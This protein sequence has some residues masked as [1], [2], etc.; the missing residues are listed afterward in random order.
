MTRR[1]I[2]LGLVALGGLL[3]A[4]DARAGLLPISVSVAPEAGNFR[5]TYAI[6]LPTDSQLQAGD[7]FTIYDFGGL[8][9]DSVVAPDGWSVVVA[10]TGTTP[11]RLTPDDHAGLPNMTFTY[12]GPT[13][14]TG[15]TGLGN[16]WA[17]ST[18]QAATDSFLTA[19]THR[20]SDGAPDSN[21]T[22]VVV[23][24]PVAPPAVPEPATLA[25]AA[26]GLPLAALVR[27]RGTRAARIAVDTTAAG[28]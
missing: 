20:T 17:T 24:V 23:P 11:P 13:I 10:N 4:A 27:R 25:L 22:E 5:W 19:R 9:P 14:T 1:P 26:L 12:T 21:I 16:F 18:F 7:Y 3:T 15:Q 2:T 8:V 28:V 6:V